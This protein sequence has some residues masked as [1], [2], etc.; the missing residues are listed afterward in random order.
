MSFAQIKQMRNFH[1]N[2]KKHIIHSVCNARTKIL[3]IGVG[4]GGDILKWHNAG[5]QNVVGVDV[6]ETYIQEARNR[7][8]NSTQSIKKRNYK[9]FK[10][11]G[12]DIQIFLRE[13]DLS[14]EYNVISCQFAIHYFFKDQTT[15][16]NFL[17]QVSSLLGKNGYFIGTA[18]SGDKIS[19]FL[20]RKESNGIIYIR[21]L[22]NALSYIGDLIHVYMHGTLYFKEHSISAEYLVFEK[23]LIEECSKHNLRL[24][25]MTPF[26]DLFNQH[27]YDISYY[28]IKET[29]FLNVA[30]IFQKV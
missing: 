3:D 30:F 7:F 13:N 21:K 8:E 23:V 4:R 18:M 16:T 27:A 19:E 15:L 24:I 29:S 12:S 6:D 20:K 11:N 25:S 1:N 10:Y 2:V 26:E 5:I 17:S 28:N 22:Y 14:T 9:F